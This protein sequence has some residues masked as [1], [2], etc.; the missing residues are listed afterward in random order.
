MNASQRHPIP[1][2][3]ACRETFL[4]RNG[5]AIDEFLKLECCPSDFVAVR[6]RTD[7][8]LAMHRDAIADSR[9][10]EVEWPLR[11]TAEFVTQRVPVCDAPRNLV[12]IAFP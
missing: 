3:P 9:S 5:A 7:C 8:Q 12:A 6:N 11:K 4:K 1:H 2:S 10:W